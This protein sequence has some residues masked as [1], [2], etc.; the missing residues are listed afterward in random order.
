MTTA[1]MMIRGDHGYKVMVEIEY[2]PVTGRVE[3]SVTSTMNDGEDYPGIEVSCAN[4]S[5][6][7]AESFATFAETM[8]GLDVA[9]HIMGLWDDCVRD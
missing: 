6:C 7:G 5:R 9:R 2:F 8:V 3:I 1:S 4:V